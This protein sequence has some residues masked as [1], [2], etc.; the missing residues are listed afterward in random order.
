MITHIQIMHNKNS[1]I[2]QVSILNN[3]VDD[4]G[5]T[6]ERGQFRCAHCNQISNWK[7]VIQ[8]LFLKN[9]LRTI[10]SEISENYT[11]VRN[12]NYED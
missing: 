7:H 5:F 4:L 6:K 3:D 11:N 1:T 10:R 8:V 12:T 9:S 2:Q